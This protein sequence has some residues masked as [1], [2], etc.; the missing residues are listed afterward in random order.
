MNPAVENTFWKAK[1]CAHCRN[2]GHI[3]RSVITEIFQMTPA[4][5]KLIMAG[6]TAHELKTLGRKEGMNTL[7]ESAIA[8]ALTGETSLEEV[9]R[10]TQ[11]GEDN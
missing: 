2:T 5:L 10:V 11:E 9:F 8:K 6:A 3:G 4:A 1:G 7:R